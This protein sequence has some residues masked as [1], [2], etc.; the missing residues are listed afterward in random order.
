MKSLEVDLA[1]CDDGDG[2]EDDKT[3]LTCFF[4]SP[5]TSC[6]GFAIKFMYD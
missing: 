2:D 1:G 4:E 6:C 5:P 3:L